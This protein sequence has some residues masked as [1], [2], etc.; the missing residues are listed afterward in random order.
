MAPAS[1]LTPIAR[2]SIREDVYALLRSGILNHVYPP[3]HR[4]DLDDPHDHDRNDS[5]GEYGR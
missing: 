5:R 1:S 2:L 3:G 4:L